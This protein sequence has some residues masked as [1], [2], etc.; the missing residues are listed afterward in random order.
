M[1]VD[2]CGYNENE[3]FY[4]TFVYR[5]FKNEVSDS[6]YDDLMINEKI[7]KI[8]YFL[9]GELFGYS[10]YGADSYDEGRRIWDQENSKFF[11]G[12]CPWFEG[13]NLYYLKGAL[14]AIRLYEK[15][16]T[17]DEVKLNYD[18]TLKYRDSFKDEKL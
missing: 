9:N 1:V 15:P 11:V 4:L 2:N 8:E 6:S 17:P 3:D 5:D 10:Y 7:D 18:M 16:L 13:G 12:V 14:Y